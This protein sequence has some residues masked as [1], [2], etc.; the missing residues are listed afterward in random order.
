MKYII[1]IDNGSQSTKVTIFD[2]HGTPVASGRQALRPNYTPSPGIVEHPHDDLWESIQ[3]ASRQA[4]AEFSGNKDDIIGVG[5]C[6]IRFCRAMLKAD[7][8][9]AHSVLS[10]MDARV[11]KPFNPQE[12]PEAQKATTSSGYI[13]HRLTGQFKDTAANYQGMWP[14]DTDTWQWLPPGEDFD[15][16]GYPRE[17]L[18]DLVMPG[19]VLGYVTAEASKATGLPATLPVI[20]TSNDKAVEALGSGLREGDVL[21]SLGTYIAGMALGTENRLDATGFWSNFASTPREYLYE[22]HGIRRGMWTVSWVCDVLDK[23]DIAEGDTQSIEEYFNDLARKVPPGCDGLMTVLDWLAPTDAPHRKGA[24]LGFDGRQGRAHMYR[25]VLEGI[26]LTMFDMVKAMSSDLAKP[27]K[28]V[29]VAG[30]GSNSDVM[31]QI[32]ADVFNLPTVRMSINNA[33]GLGGAICVAAGL[34][35]YTSFDEAI[36]QMTSVAE[37]FTPNPD[38]HKVYQALLPAYRAAQPALDPV[39]RKS[40]AVVG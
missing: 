14:I 19:D 13:T 3:V 7:G 1:G 10:W 35:V 39:F 25:S 26:A 11:S 23:K 9:L 33:A 16:Y 17:Y 4:M 27:F 36:I 24:I 18:F 40:H 2:L 31:M 21:I 30:G 22:S 5:L 12:F 32:F 38:A 20:A 8:T 29:I 34:G 6:T 15:T 37:E 28:K